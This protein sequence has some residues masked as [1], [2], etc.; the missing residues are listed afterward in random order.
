MPE[1]AKLVP[2]FDRKSSDLVDTENWVIRVEKI[3]LAFEVP[4]KLK[5]P[6]AEFQLKLNANDW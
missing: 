1:F 3:F 2:E 5:M 6:M 4:D